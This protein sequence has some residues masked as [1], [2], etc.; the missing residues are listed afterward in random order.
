MLQLM[1]DRITDR[2]MQLGDFS[3]RFLLLF[4]SLLTANV[5]GQNDLKKELRYHPKTLDEALTQ[6]DKKF[7]DS[8]K[9]K[10]INMTESD[11]VASTHFSLGRWIRNEWL[12]NR[13][14]F[15]LI[16]TQSDL[17]KELASKGL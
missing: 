5:F 4:F 3:C 13:Y 6:L 16:V 14:F 12:Y 8:S 17:R 15:R 2:P 11:F 1:H 7:T 10:I 9:V